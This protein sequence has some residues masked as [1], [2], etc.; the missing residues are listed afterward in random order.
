[1]FYVFAYHLGIQTDGI[2][3]IPFGPKMITPIGALF[4]FFKLVEH[5]DG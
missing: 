2:H 3:T 5:P 1:M 4:Q